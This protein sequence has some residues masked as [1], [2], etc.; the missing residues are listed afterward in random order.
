VLSLELNLASRPFKNNTLLWV[1]FSLAALFLVWLSLANVRSQRT[2]V[3]LLAELEDKVGT[4]DARHEDLRRRGDVARRDIG[5][6]DLELLKIKA[7]KANEV[8]H[9]K[10]FS[11]TRLFNQ[12]EQVQP[13]DVQMAS[14]HPTFRPQASGRSSREKESAVGVPVA[15]EGTAKNVKA[16]LDLE[17]AL[18]LSPYFTRVEPDRTDRDTQ[19]RETVFG[20]RFVYNPELPEGPPPAPEVEEE[21]MPAE[22]AVA[23]DALQDDEASEVGEPVEQPEVAAEGDPIQEGVEETDEPAVADEAADPP[24]GEGR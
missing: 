16:F 23:T 10:A 9:W 24:G 15:V 3:G 7:A 2:H 12:L 4:I 17:R 19:T 5:G 8:I 1:G 14:I 22:D 13:W 20:L 11:W 6:H 21:E 18:I